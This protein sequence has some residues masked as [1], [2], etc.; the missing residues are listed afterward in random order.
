MPKKYVKN[1]YHIFLIKFVVILGVKYQ[2]N[3]GMDFTPFTPKKAPKF[4]CEPC[5]YSTS[6]NKEFVRHTLTRKHR[7]QCHG[8]DWNEFYATAINQYICNDCNF[9]TCKRS[10]YD[11]HIISKKH[12]N[13]TNATDKN[14]YTCVNCN[15]IYS[16]K[17]NLNKHHKKCII[18]TNITDEK[19]A[20]SNELVLELLKQNKE[21]QSTMIEQNNKII[22]LTNK[23]TIINNTNQQFNLNMFLNET[24]KDALNIMDVLNSLQLKVEDFEET[25]RLGYVE[26]IS[27]IIINCIK[28]MD[29]EK[30]PMHCTDFKRETLYIKDENIWCKEGIDKNKFKNIVKRVAQMNLCQ[31]PNWQKKYP[32]SVKVNTKEN[33]EYVKLSL[34]ALGSR[35]NE[36]EEKFMDKIMKNVLKEVVLDKKNMIN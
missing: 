3:I 1:C 29:V 11:R 31:L 35:T 7:T 33:D 6:N 23:P 10:D 22:E 15:N 30:R 8:S 27:R 36:E 32:E 2:S 12:T 26:G 34:A 14:K 13:N 5:H 24:C 19:T 28:D 21:F 9:H 25:G 17:S 16:N 18:P 4:L 20:L